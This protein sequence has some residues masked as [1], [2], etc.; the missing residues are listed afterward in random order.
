MVRRQHVESLPGTDPVLLTVAQEDPH[1]DVRSA[2]VARLID[3]EILHRLA[4]ND[5]DP[6]IRARATARLQTVLAG[7]DGTDVQVEQ[8]L[9]FLEKHGNDK[10]LQFTARAGQETQL[11]RRALQQLLQQD[12]MEQYESLFCDIAAE[13]S[14]GELRE[15]AASAVHSE[16]QLE[17]LVQ[18]S[19][20][21]DKA[22]YRLAKE[23][24]DEL[25]ALR[26]ARTRIETCLYE[27]EAI[28]REAADCD[29]A[30][31]A[32]MEL[33]LATVQQNWD[34]S[35]AVLGDV[36]AETASRFEQTM[37]AT[38]SRFETV[39]Q[40]KRAR[41]DL[42]KLLKDK[43]DKSEAEGLDELRSQWTALGG[44]SASED[45]QFHELM[46][47]LEEHRLR[48]ERDTER[49]AKVERFLKSVDDL[50]SVDVV[51]ARRVNDLQER[52]Q[53]LRL[54]EDETARAGFEQ[55]FA[56]KLDA[57]RA[58]IKATEAETQAT[59]DKARGLV[60]AY[61]AA[62]A[63]DQLKEASS[64]HDKAVSQLKK[65]VAAE[66]GS[67]KG[68]LEKRLHDGEA[69][70]TELRRWRH[71]ATQQAR[72]KLCKRAEELSEEKND[73]P[74]IAKRVRELRD[75]WK[76]LDHADG[77]AP[78]PLWEQF[79]TACEK[80]YAPCQAY[81]DKQKEQRDK[82][83]EAREALCEKLEKLVSTTDWENPQWREVTDVLRDTQRAWYK[84][85]PVDRRKKK[86]IDKRFAQA[87][88]AVD[89]QLE[90]KRKSELA[91]REA[92]IEK[93]ESFTP[94]S[95][96]SIRQ[97]KQAQRDW[98]P[99]VQ[100]DRKT[101]RK[102]WQRFRTACDAVFEQRRS[103]LA[104]VDRERAEHLGEK[105]AVIAQLEEA[106]ESMQKALDDGTA[107]RAC[108]RDQRKKLKQLST[109]W[110]RIGPVPRDQ[111]KG[112]EQQ[113]RKSCDQLEK[114]CAGA[115]Q[116]QRQK[117]MADLEAGAGLCDD[118]ERDIAAGKAVSDE[119]RDQLAALRDRDELAPL[120]T[121]VDKLRNVIE[122]D[123]P[124]RRELLQQLE[125]NLET[126]QKLCL[127]LEI[128]ANIDSPD[129]HKQE[130]M[131]HRVNQL[132]ASLSGGGASRDAAALQR[133]WFATGTVP[134]AAESAIQARYKRA[135][136]A[137]TGRATT[138]E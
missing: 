106:C 54:P 4:Q 7:N 84:S 118:I 5:A 2:A 102:L 120:H 125:Q 76:K 49:G 73:P 63:A 99:A 91:R 93:I 134:S 117:T 3:L 58:R 109:G 131:A 95:R 82:N 41:T 57:L 13:D 6:Q 71:W 79:D 77:A 51:D 17:N 105:K 25:Q 68:A 133:E 108:A 22:V 114:L 62:L 47:S 97:V 20:T 100:C 80:A 31:M 74:T 15:A 44:A 48:S 115:E 24:L 85:G 130:R 27:A 113:F 116:L 30:E 92:M 8:R 69:K 96:D 50:A 40:E 135:I 103:Q 26:G 127:E 123:D 64:A 65:C 39:R 132:S 75:E 33:R 86:K 55:A 10:L 14:V 72:E 60:E 81:F 1:P 104:E 18:R 34:R 23:R 52:W 46:Q 101:E 45:K 94:E 36:D 38:R 12:Q 29:A 129:E 61:E 59:L 83:M 89:A 53:S 56:S 122:G 88:A 124:A 37:A 121:R 90:P 78:K 111:E 137:L 119:Q 112:V 42:L 32:A 21:R 98:K 35:V 126:K 28:A 11:R 136:E 70:L 16:E 9:A 110:R 87:V 138:S 66:F 19:K 67:Q 107:D 43:H 128:A